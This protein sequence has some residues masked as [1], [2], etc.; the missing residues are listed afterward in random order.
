MPAVS[1]H[2]A[3]AS[4]LQDIGAAATAAHGTVAVFGYLQSGAGGD[5]GGGG[6]DI[7][8]GGLISPGA[9]GINDGLCYLNRD[10]LSLHHPGQPYNLVY[11][12]SLDA[13]RGSKGGNLS[14]GSLAAHYLLHH[15]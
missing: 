7:K 2:W 8:A 5:K 9:A 10:C 4:A 12:L 14:R 13:Q 6:R 1:R 15:P 3:T 11:C